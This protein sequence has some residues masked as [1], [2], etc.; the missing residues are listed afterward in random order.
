MDFTSNRSVQQPAKAAPGG[1]GSSAKSWKTSPKWLRLIWIVLLFSVTALVVSML[2]LLYFGG[3]KE[4][5][6]VV[7]DR[8]QAVFLTNGQVYFG[9]INAINDQY[10][11]LQNIY[12]LSVD[13]K[14]QPE[15]KSDDKSQDSS[16]SLVKLGCE[17]HGPMDQMIIN[18]EQ[19]T[20]WENLRTDGQVSDAIKK[21]IEQNPN[22]QKCNVPASSQQ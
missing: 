19:V 15:Q 2:A 10:I 14:V 12:Y 3:P 16:V 17:L 7:K 18:R 4:S 5:K 1:H 13:Q 22:G 9:D 8:V 21:W 20:F 11:D 6:Y